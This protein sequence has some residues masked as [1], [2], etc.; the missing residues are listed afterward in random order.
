MYRPGRRALIVGLLL[1][2]ILSTQ[3][4]GGPKTC[5]DMVE[6]RFRWIDRESSREKDLTVEKINSGIEDPRVIDALWQTIEDI[7]PVYESG[8]SYSEV[9]ADAAQRN[10]SS[11]GL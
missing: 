3:S 7:L 4:C 6:W 9:L 2:S 5:A 8:E 11:E 1:L 10:C